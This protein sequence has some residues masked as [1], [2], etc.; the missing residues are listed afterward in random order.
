MMFAM[1]GDALL[2]MQFFA[3]FGESRFV[4]TLDRMPVIRTLVTVQTIV[5]AD[6][7]EAEIGFMLP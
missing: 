2:G 7:I 3:H 6:R 1:A 5:V 4:E